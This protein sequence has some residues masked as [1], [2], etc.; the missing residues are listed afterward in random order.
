MPFQPGHKLAKGGKR[1]GAGRKSNTE[2]AIQKTVEERIRAYIEQKIDPVL[3]TY[4]KNA[5]GHYETRYTALGQ[6]YE[7]WVVDA[8]TTR[9]WIDKFVPAR[10]PE[11]KKGNAVAPILYVTNLPDDD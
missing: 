3:S 1:K 6:A 11:D 9:H 4:F 8:A 10:A 7:V 5:E 2:K